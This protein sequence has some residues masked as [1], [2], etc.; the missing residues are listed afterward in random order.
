ML[1]SPPVC[2]SNQM[3]I[4]E[5]LVLS[6]CNLAVIVW[7]IRRQGIVSVE[8]YC[9][10]WIGMAVFTDNTQLLFDYVFQP[11][12]LSLGA[13]EFHFRTFPTF[14][15][16]IA[17]LALLAGLFLGNSKP[18]PVRR[19]LSGADLQFIA[20]TG[21]FLLLLGLAFSGVAIYLTRAY[22]ATNFFTALD[23]FRGGDPGH[24]SGFWYRGADISVFG[25]G[26]MLASVGKTSVRFYALLAGM[27]AVSFFLRANQGGVEFAILWA[28]LILYT[29]NG[30]RLSEVL[31]PSLI[32]GALVIALLGIG[33]KSQLLKDDLQP[34]TL[35][36]MA[37][38][39]T[40]PVQA[41]WGDEGLYRGYCQFIN[42]LP[43]YHYL[44]DGYREGWYALTQAW[45][46]RA[47]RSDKSDQP[48]VGLGY[49][50]HSDFHEYYTETPSVELVGSVYA[51]DGFYTLTAYLLLVGCLLGILRR[52]AASQGSALQWHVSYVAFVLFGGLSAESGIAGLIYTFLLTFGITGA[53]HLLVVG[54]FKRRLQAQLSGAAM[55]PRDLRRA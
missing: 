1:P 51:D 13:D 25:M 49:M 16:I 42:L 24:S 18:E 27:I 33:I 31:K 21:V 44:F 8:G 38:H 55:T 2:L 19:N 53:A 20:N 14:V 37:D 6:I 12:A 47:L 32:V 52:Y 28:V 17:L 9:V 4:V 29:Y 35:E 54:M 46:P 10:A 43:K 41:R 3:D 7:V 26:L 5:F 34:L 23:A 15:H 45:I 48:T 36:A 11:S 40:G 22:Q 30:N 39:I 50:V